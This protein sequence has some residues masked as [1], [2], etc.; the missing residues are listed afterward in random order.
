[1]AILCDLFLSSVTAIAET[2]EFVV[3]DASGTRVAPFIGGSSKVLILAG[4]HKIVPTLEEA[5]KRTET[6]CYP[7]ESARARVAY[8]IP[9]SVLSN[10]LIIRG[11]LFTPGRF[12]MV[13]IKEV[14]GF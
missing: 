14:L 10:E 3:C 13:L 8:K 1:M 4:T 6:F 7:L 12:T 5:L 11:C 9:G 2:G